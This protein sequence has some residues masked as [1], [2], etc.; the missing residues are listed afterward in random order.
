MSLSQHCNGVVTN[1]L[2]ISTFSLSYVV[3]ESQVGFYLY[4]RNVGETQITEENFYTIDPSKK[5]HFIIHGWVA[6]H[7]LQWVQSMTDAYLEQDDSNVIQ[8]DW[9]EPAFESVYISANNTKAVG[10]FVFYPAMR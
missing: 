9:R 1:I 5:F 3:K 6:N 8:V 4:T 10:L 2:V 7:E